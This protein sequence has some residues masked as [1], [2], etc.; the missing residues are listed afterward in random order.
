MTKRELARKQAEHMATIKKGIDIE[1]LTRALENGMTT[2][3]LEKAINNWN[4]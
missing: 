1:K 2:R 4:K 3:Q